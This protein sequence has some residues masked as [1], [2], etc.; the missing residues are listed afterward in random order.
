MDFS[1][2]KKKCV[3]FSL[4]CSI[5]ALNQTTIVN[6]SLLIK[7]DDE[8]KQGVDVCFNSTDWVVLQDLHSFD[9]CY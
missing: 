6:A 4:E 2:V 8:A 9:F 5:F 1:Q 7:L 3:K